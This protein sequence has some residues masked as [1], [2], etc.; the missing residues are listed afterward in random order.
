[1]KLNLEVFETTAAGTGTVVLQ[2]TEIEEARLKSYELGYAAGWEDAVAAAKEEEGRFAVELANNL[3]HLSFT[4]QQAR[5]HLLTSIR[6][7]LQELATRLLPELSREALA[8]VVLDTLMPLIDDAADQPIGLK[9][10][11]LAR[12]AVERLLSQAA[13]LPLLIEEEPT[14]GEGQVYLRLG[15]AE[16]RV[17][18]DQA[19]AE[20][21]KAVHDFFDYSERDES[22]G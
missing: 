8:P 13:G 4:Y 21:I 2:S 3:Q 10:N 17:D 18:L 19:T 15:E 20:I 6:P 16:Y 22:D 1:M 5:R 11:P 7:V 9:L 14:L 12:P